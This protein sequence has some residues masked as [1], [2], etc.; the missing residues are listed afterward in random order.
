MTEKGRIHPDRFLRAY[1]EFRE[2]VDVTRGGVL[3]EVDDVVCYMLIGFPRVPADDEIG[4][5]AKMDAIDQ[6]VSIF[7]ALFV[8][9]NK[10]SPEQFV[11][12]G[13]KRYDQAAVTAK[14]LLE[15]KDE[16][17]PDRPSQAPSS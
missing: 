3:P 8:E 6:R 15:E 13:L 11:D 14:S 4:E 9:I 10:D 5:H 2:Q 12:E 16:V 17:D 7:K 1:H